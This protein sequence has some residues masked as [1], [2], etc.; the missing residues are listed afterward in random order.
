MVLKELDEALSNDTGGAEDTDGDFAV[1]HMRP[2]RDGYL[3]IL[4]EES[5]V[6]GR[7]SSARESVNRAPWTGK[8]RAKAQHKGHEGCTKGTKTIHRGGAETRRDLRFTTWSFTV[9][10]EAV[11]KWRD[12]RFRTWSL[13]VQVEAVRK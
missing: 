12:L 7:W 1:H 13:T 6:V 3:V 2:E 4:H 5:L 9:R 11:R 8:T 10:V